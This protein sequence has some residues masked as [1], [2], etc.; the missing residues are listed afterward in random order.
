MLVPRR[1]L[2][3]SGHETFHPFKAPDM[4]NVSTFLIL[5]SAFPLAGCDAFNESYNKGFEKSFRESCVS[6]AV[7]QG[8]PESVATE[9]CN[10]TIEKLQAGNEDGGPVF[11]SQEEQIAAAQACMN[12]MQ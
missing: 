4:K 3:Q 11:P 7:A 8:A 10:C 12:E 1:V 6:T 5:A 2:V 9:A